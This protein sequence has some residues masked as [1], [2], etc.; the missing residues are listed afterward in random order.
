MPVPG[1]KTAFSVYAAAFSAASPAL[2]D[3]LRTLLACLDNPSRDPGQS[4]VVIS[5]MPLAGTRPD[6]GPVVS[7]PVVLG[8]RRR[9]RMADRPRSRV[10]SG[11]LELRSLPSGPPGLF[12][13]PGA[14]RIPRGDPPFKTALEL[15]WKFAAGR[16]H[17]DR[18]VLWRLALDGD[19]DDSAIDGGSLGAAFAV[20]LHELL[21]R[22]ASGRAVPAR[23][24][25]FFVGLRPQCAITGVLSPQPP[26]SYRPA[27]RGTSG[28]WLDEVGHL[29]AKFQVARENHLRLVAPA[30]AIVPFTGRAPRWPFTGLRPSA[31]PTGMPGR[32][33]RGGPPT[34][35]EPWPWWRGSSR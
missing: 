8:K 16:H 1:E 13:H 4:M 28:P 2:S 26:S 24:R 3:R 29:D 5:A 18:C 21:R 34:P 20:A 6:V 17:G 19:A 25:A 7:V 11:T 27:S 9:G 22:P 15:A 31:K 30:V 23:I 32:Y 14:M 35:R 10:L 12:P 33:A